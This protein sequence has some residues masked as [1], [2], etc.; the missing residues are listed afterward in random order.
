M[1]Y[2][3]EVQIKTENHYIYKKIQNKIKMETNKQKKISE[4]EKN[5][6]KDLKSQEVPS[7]LYWDCDEVCAFFDQLNLPQYKVITDSKY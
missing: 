6:I 3:I 7:C 4:F 2:K 1:S 5:K